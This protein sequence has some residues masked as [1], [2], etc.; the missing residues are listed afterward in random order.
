MLKVKIKTLAEEARI[1]RLEERRSKPG[2][3][4]QGELHGHRVHTLR[5][6]QRYSLL[7]YAFLRGVPLSR[8]EKNSKSDPDY[9]RVAKIVGKFGTTNASEYSGQ[10]VNLRKWMRGEPVAIAS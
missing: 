8:V 10:T 9:T 2:S 4:R 3:Q 6:D 7:A 5:T 1:I